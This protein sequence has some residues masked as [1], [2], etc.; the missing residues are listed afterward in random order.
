MGRDLYF[1]VTD[2]DG[3]PLKGPDDWD[4]PSDEWETVGLGSGDSWPCY[5]VPI[6]IAAYRRTQLV[7]PWNEA[8]LAAIESVIPPLRTEMVLTEMMSDIRTAEVLREAG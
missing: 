8:A 1:I 6:Y 7:E 3:R 4:E 2:P 5:F